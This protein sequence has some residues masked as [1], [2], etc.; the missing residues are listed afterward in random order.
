MPAVVTAHRQTARTA[1]V[2]TPRLRA[3]GSTQYPTSAAPASPRRRPTRPE[4]SSS[5]SILSYELSQATVIPAS[6]VRLLDVISR[7]LEPVGRGNLHEALQH[8]VQRYLVD[9]GDVGEGERAQR[10]PPGLDSLPVHD[11]SLA[12]RARWHSSGSAARNGV[13]DRRGCRARCLRSASHHRHTVGP[14]RLAICA[15]Q[16]ISTVAARSPHH[17][18]LRRTCAQAPAAPRS[19]SQ[20]ARA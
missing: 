2:A 6:D 5:G 11:R 13:K 12:H 14:L 10:Q 18:L 20:S 19:R 9:P 3:R 4:W 16:A 15:G 7:I 1:V 17:H 8:R